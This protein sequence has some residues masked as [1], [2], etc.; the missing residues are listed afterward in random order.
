[1]SE[2]HTKAKVEQWAKKSPEERSAI[3]SK[4]ARAKHQKMT[5]EQRVK[6]SMMMNEVKRNKQKNG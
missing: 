5:K 6:H 1:M 4:V 3:M 2:T